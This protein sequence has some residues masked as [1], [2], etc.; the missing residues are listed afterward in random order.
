M[1][2]REREGGGEGKRGKGPG[3]LMSH[4]SVPLLWVQEPPLVAPE[5]PFIASYCLARWNWTCQHLYPCHLSLNQAAG[6]AHQRRRG[7]SANVQQK[8]VMLIYPYSREKER[9]SCKRG[10]KKE[11]RQ[12]KGKE[13]GRIE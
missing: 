8:T 9:K 6:F 2:V 10:R 11:K 3:K 4:I 13:E 1:G 5:G 12:E 7:K